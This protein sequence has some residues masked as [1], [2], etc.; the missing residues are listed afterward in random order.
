MPFFEMVNNGRETHIW[1][2]LRFLFF[3]F[4][5]LCVKFELHSIHAKWRCQIGSWIDDSRV[6]E[7]VKTGD[8]SLGIHRVQMECKA[9]GPDYITKREKV[10]G[11]EKRSKNQG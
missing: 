11:E 6:K 3:F 9:L 4:L 1:A 10:D 2:E 7:E 5:I 8:I